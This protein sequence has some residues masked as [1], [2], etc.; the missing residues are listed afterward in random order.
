MSHN[1]SN[2]LV[3][4]YGAKTLAF[5]KIQ[6]LLNWN[7]LEVFSQIILN[8]QSFRFEPELILVSQRR[9]RVRS[10]WS[11]TVIVVLSVSPF[12]RTLCRTLKQGGQ[13]LRRRLQ[14]DLAEHLAPPDLGEAHLL[15]HLDASRVVNL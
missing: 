1:F 7:S 13:V 3:E 11:P 14:G 10:Y 15:K 4:F 5:S 9:W 12:D 2:V 8:N 6:T